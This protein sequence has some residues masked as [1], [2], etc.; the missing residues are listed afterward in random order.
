VHRWRRVE[1]PATPFV[2]NACSENNGD[3]FNHG[4]APVPEAAAADF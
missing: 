2:T 4:L 3:F 1:T